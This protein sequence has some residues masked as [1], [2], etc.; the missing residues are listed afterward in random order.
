MAEEAQPAPRGLSP[1]AASWNEQVSAYREEHGCSLKEAMEAC[2]AMR[3]GKAGKAASK[4][5]LLL[6]RGKAR[7]NTSSLE[8]GFAVSG[9][10]GYDP[11]Y[12]P[13]VPPRGSNYD[14]VEG[15]FGPTFVPVNRRNPRGGAV[16]AR[17]PGTCAICNGSY[18]RG[19]AVC[20]SGR[21]GPKGGKL[22]AHAGCC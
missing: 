19:E 12:G 18:D 7:K 9:L 17:W 4:R 8:H 14:Q 1:A 15:A 16:E 20:D 13:S 11:S 3:K 2:S 21:R 22:K 6:P 5:K 10:F